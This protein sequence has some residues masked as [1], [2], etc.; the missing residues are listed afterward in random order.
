MFRKY[1]VFIFILL[2]MNVNVYAESIIKN[3]KL[4][5]DYVSM[6]EAFK[7]DF[8]YSCALDLITSD[9]IGFSVSVGY[10]KTDSIDER[11]SKLKIVPVSAGILYYFFPY[12]QISPYF[13]WLIDLNF[14]SKFLQT[15]ILGY[16]VKAGFFFRMD[17][18]SG[19]F[20]EVSK[21]LMYD[22]RNDLSFDPFTISAG[23][24]LT[25]WGLEDNSQQKINDF[26]SKRRR[27]SLRRRVKRR[28]LI[29]RELD[30][31]D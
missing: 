6:S 21:R 17:K 2:L 15:P 11:F 16:C 4:S 25:L 30:L 26:E 7:N 3:L 5:A 27:R 18:Y 13:A 24:A 20:A 29:E 8:Q 31:M 10:F 12:R 22:E 9:G 23:L 1:F 14:T 19:I 28:R